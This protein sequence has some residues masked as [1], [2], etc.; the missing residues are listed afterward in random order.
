MTRLRARRE[1]R[2]PGQ[3]G[4]HARGVRRV[5][6]SAAP[7]EQVRQGETAEAQAGV[8]EELSAG[9]EELVFEDGVHVSCE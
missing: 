5:G 2:E 1:M 8:A 4:M 3:A 7:A 6:E 9:L